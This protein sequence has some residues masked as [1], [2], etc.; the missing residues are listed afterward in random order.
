VTQGVVSVLAPAG[1][2]PVGTTSW[3][4]QEAELQHVVALLTRHGRTT[5][6]WGIVSSEAAPIL[7]AT[8]HRT[9]M[10]ASRS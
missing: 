10:L 3:V 6:Q 2:A 4:R 5:V 7:W 9:G 1:F 8:R